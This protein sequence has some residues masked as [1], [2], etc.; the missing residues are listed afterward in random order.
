MRKLIKKEKNSKKIVCHVFK[1]EDEEMTILLLAQFLAVKFGGVVL[2]RG[3]AW[4]MTR[5]K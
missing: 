3:W 5:C 4:G 1:R 2:L